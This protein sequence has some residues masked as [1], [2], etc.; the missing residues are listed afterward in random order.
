MNK[1]VDPDQSLASFLYKYAERYFDGEK[2]YIRLPE[3]LCAKDEVLT[4][5]P[6]Q[7]VPDSV[8]EALKL[9]SVL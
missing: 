7:D 9:D 2:Y 3:F 4:L 5:L 6:I 8:L 1:I